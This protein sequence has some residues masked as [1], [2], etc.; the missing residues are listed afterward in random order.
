MK[1]S[2]V[3]V[4]P[5]K[6]G[7][8]LNIV[9]NLLSFRRPD[10]FTTAAILVHNPLSTD[11][12]FGGVLAA[13]RQA[14]VEYVL[15]I[16][17][18]YAVL[19]RL[20]R[21]IPPGEGVLVANDWLELAMLCRHDPGRT[22]FQILHGDHDY[23]YE[24]AVKHQ[25]AIDVFVAYSHAMW[26][27]LKT[28]LP[29]RRDSIFHVPYGIP[30]PDRVR[31]P[32][33]GP[34]RLVYAGRLENGQK[35]IFDLPEIDR[36]LTERGARVEWTIVG[37]GPDA[38]ELRRRFKDATNVRWTGVLSNR[39]TLHALAEHD[40]FVLPTRAEG[41]PVALL[42]A[43]GAGCV[44]V[45]SDIA[46]G[47]PEAVTP[48]TNGFRPAVG[49]V[50][51]FASAIAELDAD[52]EALEAMSRK[53]RQTVVERFDVRERVADYQLLYARFRELRRAR[54]ER[55]T[56]PYGSRL[57]K[58]WLPNAAVYAVR[59]MARSLQGKAVP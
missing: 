41:F 7:G 23:Y 10:G 19:R 14:T 21:A 29:A 32:R 31:A 46:S 17:N 54:P 50:L 18:L 43:M 42:E 28:L 35:G 44:P 39:E 16:E 34:L 4:L 1:P 37:G 33:R 53:A 58:P 49:D 48:R 56:V 13:D 9:Q 25:D 30:I 11:T 12:R 8:L 45:V 51:G 40:L 27:K 38:P 52:R 22:V 24:L 47:V 57:D 20:V 3:Y 6:M 26:E 2:V 55:M 5:D 36:A 15:P 59:A